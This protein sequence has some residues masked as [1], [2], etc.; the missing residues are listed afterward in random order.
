MPL[1][2]RGQGIAWD[3]LSKG[4]LYGMIRATSE[5][6]AAGISKK[7]VCSS[8]TPKLRSRKS[9]PIGRGDLASDS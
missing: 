2:I 5:E 8:R 4:I 6:E 1:N 9:V 7:V 3:R